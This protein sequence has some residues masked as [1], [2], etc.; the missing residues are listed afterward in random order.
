[1]KQGTKKRKQHALRVIGTRV[2]IF[3]VYSIF[4]CFICCPREEIF[5]KV[6]VLFLMLG[7]GWEARHKNVQENGTHES[8]SPVAADEGTRR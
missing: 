1:M 4:C 7:T 6:A 8:G 2:C 3:H 5:P